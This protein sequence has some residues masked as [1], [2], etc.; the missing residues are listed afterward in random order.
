[1]DVMTAGQLG[2]TEDEMHVLKAGVG[3]WWGSARADDS[4]ASALG[5][6]SAALMENDLEYLWT[7]VNGPAALPIDAWA[8]VIASTRLVSTDRNASGED[9]PSV[10][11]FD[12]IET[13][14]LLASVEAR[15]HAHRQ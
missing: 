7:A 6:S 5:Y 9:W 12:R 14:E 4:H 2:L 15:I 13:D 8:R 3:E 1:M 11:G 10:T